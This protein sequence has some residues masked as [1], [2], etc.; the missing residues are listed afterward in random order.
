MKAIGERLYGMNL[1]KVQIASNDTIAELIKT[2]AN[3]VEDHKFGQYFLITEWEQVGQKTLAETK[4]VFGGELSGHFYFRDNFFCDSGML[5][6][7]HLVN[8][9]TENDK[10][11]SELIAPLRRYHSSGER[12]FRTSDISSSL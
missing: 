12:N 10:P 11:L 2:A 7:V 1:G 9:L 5:A 6:M 3:Q 4:G 8:T